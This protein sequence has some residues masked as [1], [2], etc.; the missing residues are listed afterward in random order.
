MLKAR[1]ILE[2]F[3]IKSEL[4]GR[5]LRKVRNILNL[6][7]K[8]KKKSLKN[9]NSLAKVTELIHNIFP[10]RESQSQR[11]FCCIS[12]D[13]SVS[14]Y[15]ITPFLTFWCRQVHGCTYYIHAVCL[16]HGQQCSEYTTL[17][18]P[19]PKHICSTIVWIKTILLTEYF[20]V[21]NKL[22]YF[23]TE[24]IHTKLEQSIF[25]NANTKRQVLRKIKSVY[26][27]RALRVRGGA[28]G[29]WTQSCYFPALSIGFLGFHFS[30]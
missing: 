20:T 2:H 30:Y 24:S 3:K 26:Y 16:R 18:S 17:K 14:P 7:Q 5:I 8:K 25:R 11:T 27:R 6:H 1:L 21:S 12:Q 10:N 15:P 13:L 9:L 23:V 29:V 22:Q 28:S 4:K 19:K